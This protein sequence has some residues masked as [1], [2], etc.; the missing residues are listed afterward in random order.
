MIAYGAWSTLAHGFTMTIMSLQ[1]VAHGTHRKD[2]PQDIVIMGVIGVTLLALLPAKQ[3]SPVSAP[4]NEPRL[5]E[6]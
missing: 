4:V 1:A 6:R 3:P 5:A 2:S